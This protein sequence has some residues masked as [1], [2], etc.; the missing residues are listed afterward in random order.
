MYP[1]HFQ[2]ESIS[3]EHFEVFALSRVGPTWT[4]AF[5]RLALNTTLR[6]HSDLYP[7]VMFLLRKVRQRHEESS[8]YGSFIQPGTLLRCDGTEPLH[9]EK[10]DLSAIFVCCPYF[11][12]GEK[13]PASPPSNVSLHLTRG[14][15]QFNYPQEITLDREADQIFARMK[16]VQ[17]HQYLRV[18]QLWAMILQ[19]ETIITC[20]P[21]TLSESIGD[22]IELVDEE[23]LLAMERLVH[24][25][26]FMKRVH[27]IPVDQ[28]RS[29]LQLRQCIQQQCLS[30]TDCHIDNCILHTGNSD[31]E[32][33]ASYWPDII[34]AERSIFI[35]VRITRKAIA[36]EKK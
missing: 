32:L 4:N 23:S 14:L 7:V 33:T 29:F 17:S 12:I 28:C 3:F 22:H 1:S 11:D 2:T 10:P 35:Y 27:Y 5:Q 19:S 21:S 18:P 36:K 15:F 20:G 30:D 13:R 34:K 6:H 25:T 8:A 31:E 9:W 24:V 16:G 26:D